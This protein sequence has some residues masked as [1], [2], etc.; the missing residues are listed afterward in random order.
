MNTE[1]KMMMR[2]VDLMRILLRNVNDNNNESY[3][4]TMALFRENLNNI[5]IF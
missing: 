1:F 2:F 5:A 3:I 4:Q